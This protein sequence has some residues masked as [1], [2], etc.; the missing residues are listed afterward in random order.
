MNNLLGKVKEVISENEHLHEAQKN[1]LISRM[2]HTYNAGSET[3]ELD[4]VGDSTGM[5][6]DNKVNGIITTKYLLDKL[7]VL[8]SYFL[9]IDLKAKIVQRFK[10]KREKFTDEI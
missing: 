8:V 7:L 3:D 4:D 1:K 5:D 6:S 2:F 9:L 10:Q